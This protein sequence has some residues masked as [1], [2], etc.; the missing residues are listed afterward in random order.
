MKEDPTLLEYLI[1]PRCR[2]PLSDS[3][4]DEY[5]CATCGLLYQREWAGVERAL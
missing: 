2:N 5:L 1:C 4:K 3:A